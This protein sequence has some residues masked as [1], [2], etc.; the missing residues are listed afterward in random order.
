MTSLKIWTK[1]SR[2]VSEIALIGTRPDKLN[3][4]GQLNLIYLPESF[5]TGQYF[6]LSEKSI[7][8][9][10]IVFCNNQ[11]FWW[12]YTHTNLFSFP[13][14][15]ENLS[16]HNFQ[17]LKTLSQLHTMWNN[18]GISLSYNLSSISPV[19]CQHCIAL[20]ECLQSVKSMSSSF[21]QDQQPF[22]VRTQLEQSAV[23]GLDHLKSLSVKRGGEA[24]I[25]IC[26]NRLNESSLH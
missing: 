2:K 9:S 22:M 11:R 1:H 21:L 7:F 3:S 20:L 24:T 13:E 18:F 25:S 17:W 19:S 23:S 15:S 16:Q 4:G 6:L 5:S 14:W 8:N 26:E 10:K 12:K